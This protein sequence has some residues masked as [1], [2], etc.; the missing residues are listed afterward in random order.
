[1]ESQGDRLTQLNRDISVLE[2]ESLSHRIDD[3]DV[4]LTSM[5]EKYRH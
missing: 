5:K 3:F 2:M 1:M 4:F